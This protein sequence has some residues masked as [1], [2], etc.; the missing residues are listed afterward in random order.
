MKT[1]RCGHPLPVSVLY[2]TFFEPVVNNGIHETQVKQ[3]LCRL[4]ATYGNSL[5]LSYCALLPAVEVG[6]TEILAPFATQ[7]LE[8]I[9]LKNEFAA[10]GVNASVLYLPLILRKRW[11]SDL[12]FLVLFLAVASSI[13]L[14]IYKL[15][16]ARPD[17]VHCRSYMATLLAVLAKVVFRD[18][19]IIF[20]P[21]GFWPEEGVVEGRWK[22]AS[23]R[24]KFWK[25]VEQWLIR[26]SDR[27]IALSTPFADRIA[28]LVPEARCSVIYTCADVE[29]FSEGR[30]QRSIKRAE[31]KLE[32]RTVFVY[33]GSLYAWHDPL[34]LARMYKTVRGLLN[35]TKLVVVTGHNRPKL[36]ASFVAEG[37]SFDDYVIIN[38][39]PI[40]VPQYLAVGD[41][42]LVPLKAI[43]AGSAM[44]VVADTMIGTK[45]AEYLAAGLPIIVNQNVGGLRPLMAQYKVGI[46]FDSENLPAMI[47]AIKALTASYGQYQ[48][49]CELVA[50]RC[51]SLEQVTSSY[52]RI[53]TKIT[54]YED[55]RNSETAMAISSSTAISQ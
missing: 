44:S 13:P 31:L 36:I 9:A 33:N 22:E 17:I 16:R 41:Y 51:F 11:A 39:K 46:S 40:D 45:V 4:G 42:G 3:L 27:V 5:K 6:R 43:A 14:L 7:R 26:R 32:D 48:R 47:E 28:Q 53:Y 12:P 25:Y 24:F 34:L 21:R 8:L 30:N 38:A 35:R 18:I 20:D 19:K 37:L 23:I 49:E 50:R 2:L 52:Y 29:K 54:G 10:S 15:F 55:D 1:S